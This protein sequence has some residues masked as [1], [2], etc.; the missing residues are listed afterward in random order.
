[1]DKL[2]SL[3]QDVL[4]SRYPAASVTESIKDSVLRKSVGLG[5]LKEEEKISRIFT[6][7]F[8]ACRFLSSR[9]C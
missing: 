5:W 1:M 2:D 6:Q 3:V 4:K 9:A 8:D 7:A